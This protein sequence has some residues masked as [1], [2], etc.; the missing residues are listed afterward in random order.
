M[1]KNKKKDWPK[2]P[3]FITKNFVKN[4]KDSE[5]D[6]MPSE[7]KD[8]LERYLENSDEPSSFFKGA[9]LSFFLCLSF[10]TVLIILI[11]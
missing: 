4:D 2:D 11:T 8:I 3:N 5:E 1:N 6:L 9:V 7:Q 10:W